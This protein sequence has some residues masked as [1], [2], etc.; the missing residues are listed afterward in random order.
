MIFKSKMLLIFIS[1]LS[2]LS[3]NLLAGVVTD[4][5]DFLKAAKSITNFI[6]NHNEFGILIKNNTSLYL[7]RERQ[8]ENGSNYRHGKVNEEFPPLIEPETM[9]YLISTSR[10]IGAEGNNNYTVFSF[11][12]KESIPKEQRQYLAISWNNPNA[13]TST[14][15]LDIGSQETLMDKLGWNEQ[16]ISRNK[17]CKG[18]EEASSEFVCGL[19]LSANVNKY[20]GDLTPYAYC[21]TWNKKNQCKYNQTKLYWSTHTEIKNFEIDGIA[22]TLTTSFNEGPD[23][24]MIFINPNR[25]QNLNV[26]PQPKV[27]P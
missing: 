14:Y 11:D 25:H 5:D 16:E 27:T 1:I 22:Y 12:T 23:K 24:L 19:I 20:L 6:S 10:S 2:F 17:N 26:I 7:E 13:G 8:S 18:L 15:R 3:N 4:T 9:G 21:F